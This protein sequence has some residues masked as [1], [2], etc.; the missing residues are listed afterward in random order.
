[1]KK[2]I[3]AI[4]LCGLFLQNQ[5][6]FSMD[7]G[8]QNRD[9]KKIDFVEELYKHQPDLVLVHIFPFLKQEDIIKI[10]EV[11]EKYSLIVGCYFFSTKQTIF[12]HP[13]FGFVTAQNNNFNQL[14][15]KIGPLVTNLPKEL[16]EVDLK[17]PGGTLNFCLGIKLP[18]CGANDAYRPTSHC[19]TIIETILSNKNVQKGLTCL[20]FSNTKDIAGSDGEFRNLQLCKNIVDLNL[21]M[22]PIFVMAFRGII[23]ELTKLKKLKV[24]FSNCM[25]YKQLGFEVPNLSV[26]NL[27][28]SSLTMDPNK[29]QYQLLFVVNM[30]PN[31]EKL[32]VNRIN[33]NRDYDDPTIL[34]NLKHLKALCLKNVVFGLMHLDP[35]LVESKLEKLCLYDCDI[36]GLNETNIILCSNIRFLR[37][38]NKDNL[39]EEDLNLLL[40]KFP[41]LE[42]LEVIDCKN[43]KERI[44]FEELV[45][46]QN[47]NL[48]CIVTSDPF[49]QSLSPNSEYYKPKHFQNSEKTKIIELFRNSD[50]E[51]PILFKRDK[52]MVPKG[53]WRVQ[54]NFFAAY[55]DNFPCE[56]DPKIR[57]VRISTFNSF[58]V[59]DAEKKFTNMFS[60]CPN[61]EILALGQCYLR[62]LPKW[63]IATNTKLKQLHLD[64]TLGQYGAVLLVKFLNMFPG[65]E[66]IRIY[67]SGHY[68]GSGHYEDFTDLEK[69]DCVIPTIHENLRDLEICGH[70]TAKGFSKLVKSLPNLRTL[71]IHNR[72]Y[73]FEKINEFKIDEKNDIRCLRFIGFNDLTNDDLSCWV[74]QFPK[75]ETVHITNCPKI[76]A[77]LKM[78]L[79]EEKKIKV[80]D[81][82]D[83]F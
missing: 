21:E 8:D 61:M 80:I 4:L 32:K 53:Y 79:T 70:M 64:T 55:S 74:K 82:D 66:V 56:R 50:V 73:K 78:L 12:I 41:G 2:R 18:D 44:N 77:E 16:E 33:R 19:N 46:S 45:I 48:S 59:K 14:L 57:E 60:F 28:I 62:E 25:E 1:M 67:E 36:I 54:D 10:S 39:S 31:I 30:F 38:Q 7:G 26:K 47:E 43:Q 63:E 71:T 42:D 9:K 81:Y 22:T 13:T 5:V 65:L 17:N 83:R 20:D 51:P 68:T 24:S 58:H 6:A 40:R 49:H 3:F 35:V 76:T 75:L 29:L 72:H 27:S 69:D 23:R 15:K 37:I 11:C 34:K 52:R